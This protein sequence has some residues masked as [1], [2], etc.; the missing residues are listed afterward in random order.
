MRELKEIG[1][2]MFMVLS[3]IALISLIIIISFILIL[4]GLWGYNNNK[5]QSTKNKF[6]S[7]IVFS[8]ILL[9]ICFSFLLYYAN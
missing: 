5:E 4:V 6:F 9:A 1:I 8:I 2:M 3:K 7:L